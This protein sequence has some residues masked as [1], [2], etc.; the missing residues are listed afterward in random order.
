MCRTFDICGVF[1]A[2]LT[3][4]LLVYGNFIGN[5]FFIFYWHY[6]FDYSKQMVP[7]IP[8]DSVGLIFAAVFNF[9][10]ACSILSHFRAATHDPGFIPHKFKQPEF[11]TEGSYKFC[12]KCP[13]GTWKPERAHHC[14]ECGHCVFK[15]DHHCPWINNCVGQKNF[16]FFI[17][18][19]M[20]TGLAAALLTIMMV[21]SF[22]HLMTAES[23]V[24]MS[25]PH[26]SYAFVACVFAFIEGILFTFFCFE[27]L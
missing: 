3:V 4:L 24:H 19:V 27:L 22:Y 10:C 12:K 1:L 25:K 8:L 11:L 2:V 7:G 17:L 14:S 6:E 15:M 13:E 5:Y 16:K 26:Y 23:K 9:F 18:F 20:Y 21:A